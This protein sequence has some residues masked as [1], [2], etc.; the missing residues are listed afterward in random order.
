MITRCCICH[1]NAKVYDRIYEEPFSADNSDAMYTRGWMCEN[2]EV[3][4][5]AYDPTS[6]EIPEDAEFKAEYGDLL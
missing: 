3:I 2:C 1:K 4:H 5:W 6:S